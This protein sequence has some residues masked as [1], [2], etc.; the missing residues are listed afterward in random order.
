[1]R[2]NSEIALAERKLEQSKQQ[3]RDQIAQAKSQTVSSQM[4]P[5]YLVVAS[6]AAAAVVGVWGWRKRRQPVSENP[7][8]SFPLRNVVIALLLPIALQL[9]A[10]LLRRA[11]SRRI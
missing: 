2:R 3:L 4:Q 6:V 9:F 10:K 8:P 5:A 1:M 7:S 11:V